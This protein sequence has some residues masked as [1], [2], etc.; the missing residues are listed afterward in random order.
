MAQI[1]YANNGPVSM[2]APQA[3]P[4]QKQS[5]QSNGTAEMARPQF[6]TNYLADVAYGGQGKDFTAYRQ[7]QA[8]D[9]LRSGVTDAEAGDYSNRE[10]LRSA[11]AQQMADYGG[12]NDT[13]QRNFMNA[14]ERGLA[15][16]VAQL[17]RQMG[18]TG[19]SRSL[20]ANRAF[21]DVLANAQRASAEGLNQFQ[22]QKG[23]ELG[24]FAQINQS[25]LSQALAERGFSLEQA[26]TLADLLQRQALAEQESILQ[27][28]TQPGPSDF[29]KGL[30][31]ALQAGGVAAQAFG[32]G[33]A[34]KGLS[35]ILGGG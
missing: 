20:Q 1:S 11:L 5:V 22:L 28:R 10:A 19:L 32:G 35:L 14:Q 23:Q 8:L 7:A 27:T 25:N 2:T 15:N 24:Q 29:E 16:N 31:Y 12:L 34:S 26:K 4:Y 21:G 9:T 3:S 18:G 13:R 6:S 30:G 17:R 33:G